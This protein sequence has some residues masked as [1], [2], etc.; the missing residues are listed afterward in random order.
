MFPLLFRFLPVQPRPLQPLCAQTHVDPILCI[1]AV[2]E[3]FVY[4]AARVALVEG[5]DYVGAVCMRVLVVVRRGWS[6]VK[7]YFSGSRRCG[8]EDAL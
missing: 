5:G 7:L 8:D 3:D 2:P 1:R 6:E 4:E